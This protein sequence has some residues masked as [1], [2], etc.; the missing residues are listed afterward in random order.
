MSGGETLKPREAAREPIAR[1]WGISADYEAIRYLPLPVTESGISH[2]VGAG[3]DIAATEQERISLGLAYSRAATEGRLLISGQG[4]GS[5][6]STEY[7]NVLARLGRQT[8]SN[9]V[10][11]SALWLFTE[12]EKV[13]GGGSISI[14]PYQRQLDEMTVEHSGESEDAF[15]IGTRRRI[16]AEIRPWGRNLVFIPSVGFAMDTIRAGDSLSRIRAG[17]EGRISVG[18]GDAATSQQN[19]FAADR[20]GEEI[21]Y[22]LAEIAH[23]GIYR[24]YSNATLARMQESLAEQ[25][26]TAGENN[27]AFFNLPAIQL[28][29]KMTGGSE[30]SLATALGSGKYWQFVFLGGYLARGISTAATGGDAD[31][32]QGIADITG[33]FLVLGGDMLAGI[34][35]AQARR[36]LGRQKVARREAIVNAA[37]AIA[38]AALF[39]G[40]AAAGNNIAADA[41]LTGFGQV[42]MAPNQVLAA[43]PARLIAVAL[44]TYS[45][46]ER[47]SAVVLQNEW[48]SSII[49]ST[50]QPV[51]TT[52]I[53]SPSLMPDNWGTHISQDKPY[54]G[55]TQGSELAHAVGIQAGYRSGYAAIRGSAGLAIGQRLGITGEN[56]TVGIAANAAVDVHFSKEPN[57]AAASLGILYFGRYVLPAGRFANS[58]IPTVGFKW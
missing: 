1:R 15:V 38:N 52:I 31:M 34:S 51:S 21:A 56:W 11:N 16:G 49:N 26:I 37:T 44:A 2:T 58:V 20:T 23:T 48:G 19:R 45:D 9:P 39:I 3:I 41:G 42:S 32:A 28:I 4:Q 12:S 53:E 54:E 6:Y 14:S 17:I 13:I 24:Y 47:G 7:W 25:G 40:G 50:W 27:P 43:R 35:T 8:R 30:D 33:P 29:S 55:S 5:T 57:S 22:G 46:G 36:R 18:Y 10:I